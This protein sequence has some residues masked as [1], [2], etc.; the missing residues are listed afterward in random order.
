MAARRRATALIDPI[1][2]ARRALL[3]V[4]AKCARALVSSS[5]RHLRLWDTSPT[6][7]TAPI[8]TMAITRL[9]HPV[10]WGGSPCAA[11]ATRPKRGHG[12]AHADEEDE[13]E[14]DRELAGPDR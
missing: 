5:A 10:A 13:R 8:A 14:Q 11:C 4:T 7:K 3:L 6:A 12:T 2:W 1:T 9:S